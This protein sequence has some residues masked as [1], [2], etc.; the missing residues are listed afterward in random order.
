ME[1]LYYMSDELF[2]KLRVKQSNKNIK[3]ECFEEHNSQ[4]RIF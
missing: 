2:E 4:E 3:G 1:N